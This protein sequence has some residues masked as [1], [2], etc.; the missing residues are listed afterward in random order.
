MAILSSRQVVASAAEGNEAILALVG[1]ELDTARRIIDGAMVKDA[2]LRVVIYIE[3]GTKAKNAAAADELKVRLADPALDGSS[4]SI[5]PT[6]DAKYDFAHDKFKWNGFDIYLT[7]VEKLVLH[8]MIERTLTAHASS[9]DEWQAEKQALYRMRQ[10]FGP[11]FP[12]F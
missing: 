11:N 2:S 6:F 8:K 5:I 12:G 3:G 9:P 1:V 4:C 10:K 7:T